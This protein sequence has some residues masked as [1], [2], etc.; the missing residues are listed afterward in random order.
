MSRL[1]VDAQAVRPFLAAGRIPL[2]GQLGL[3]VQ[4]GRVKDANGLVAR[5]GHPHFFRRRT[6]C[7]RSSVFGLT[8]QT[9]P[10]SI[11]STAPVLPAGTPPR[12][13]G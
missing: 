5:R 12:D 11:T 10:A 9:L 4:R 3:L 6:Q 7:P 2:E 8:S 13:G 1:L